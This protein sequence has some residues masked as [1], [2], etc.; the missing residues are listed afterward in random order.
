[1]QFTKKTPAKLKLYVQV[2]DYEFCESSKPSRYPRY[3][4]AVQKTEVKRGKA[5]VNTFQLQ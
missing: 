4:S 1:M 5:I 3:K 2:N